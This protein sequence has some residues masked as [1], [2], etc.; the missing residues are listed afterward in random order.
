MILKLSDL[1]WFLQNSGE[2]LANR[3]RGEVSIVVALRQRTGQE[4]FFEQIFRLV[5]IGGCFIFCAKRLQRSLEH[6]LDGVIYITLNYLSLEPL[7]SWGQTRR[8]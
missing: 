7:D 3:T 6:L 1:H 8:V 4:Y 2:R 5:A